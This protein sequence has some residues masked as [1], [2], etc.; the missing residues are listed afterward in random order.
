MTA[1]SDAVTR[2]SLD[3]VKARQF[4]ARSLRRYAAGGAGPRESWCLPPG[5]NLDGIDAGETGNVEDLVYQ[6][7]HEAGVISCPREADLDLLIDASAGVDWMYQWRIRFGASAGFAVCSPYRE[8]FR[9]LGWQD[10]TTK[11]KG[12]RT[13][14]GILR[15]AEAAG[16]ALLQ[17]LNRHR[18]YRDPGTHREYPMTPGQ[19]SG[20]PCRRGR[21]AGTRPRPGIVDGA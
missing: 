20:P 17:A 4:L 2:F 19:A 3:E 13:A 12:A 21:C 1:Q 10:S 5:W 6:A 9:S 16:N 8:D 18:S 11:A 15:E 7:I 14:L